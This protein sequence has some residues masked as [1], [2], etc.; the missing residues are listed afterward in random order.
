[1]LFALDAART[2]RPDQ[3]TVGATAPERAA[4]GRS[5]PVQLVLSVEGAAPLDCEVVLELDEGLGEPGRR[6]VSW[7]RRS[8]T[9]QLDLEL[10]PTRRGEFRVRA[11]WLRWSGP[12]RLARRVLRQPLEL[13][14]R[15][16]PDMEAVRTA[17]LRFFSREVLAG[18]KVERYVSDGSEFEALREYQSGLDPRAI[19]WNASA[20]HR[21]LLYQQF[22]AE[23]NHQLVIAVDTGHLMR[24][25]VDG[26]PKLDHAIHAA[27][28]LS[29]VGLRTGDRVGLFGF[30]QQVRAYCEPRGGLR[31]FGRLQETAASLDYA[32]V[33]TNFTLGLTE[34]STRLRRRSLVVV[35]TDFVDAVTAQ[36]ML[37]NLERLA[38]RQ[39][40]LFVALR[41][42]TLD[43]LAR[44]PPGEPAALYQTVVAQDFI[45]ER[46]QVLRRLRRMGAHL[47]D[48]PPRG[49][50]AALLQRYLDIK[51][52]E[53]V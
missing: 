10:W 4:M 14:V 44:V 5:A 1:V 21:K 45:R 32:T 53:L 13:S 39:L 22:R 34:L 7:P 52:R 29:Y 46:E 30:D 11:V 49:I 40:V 27:L 19:E 47:V 42:P 20:K 15:V 17:A 35:L 33:E 9:T 2:P 8:R 37:D 50:S 41:D 16:I 28:L 38:R 3:L 12:L 23:R 43:E 36:L 51:R 26:M 48:A 24:E 25:P 18:L 31:S 6:A